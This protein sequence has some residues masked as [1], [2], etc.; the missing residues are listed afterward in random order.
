M[1]HPQAEFEVLIGFAP[2]S[3]LS[4]IGW[5]TGL[6]PRSLKRTGSLCFSIGASF[7]ALSICF[8]YF[9]LTF[10]FMHLADTFIQSD[11]Q[12]HSGYTFLSVYV[13]PGNRTHNL[14]RCWRNALPLS[15]TGTLLMKNKYSKVEYFNKCNAD[16]ETSKL[17]HRSHILPDKKKKRHSTE[18]LYD[19]RHMKMWIN[20][21]INVS[22]L[23]C[24]THVNS[25]LSTL[26]TSP[27]N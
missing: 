15:N 8:Y 21:L 2:K 17:D 4:V 12:L 22:N 7:V 13:F 5:S 3:D 27:L 10:T 9:F 16:M 23:D 20:Q 1:P 26:H 14:L 19:Q 18:K 6:H 11:L 24:T 25:L